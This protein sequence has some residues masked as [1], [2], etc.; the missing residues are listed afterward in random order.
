MSNEWQRRYRDLERTLEH[1][2]IA[3]RAENSS[4]S[5]LNVD[6]T[7]VEN[8]AELQ[9]IE[10]RG[11]LYIVCKADAGVERY[12]F[13][14]IKENHLVQER[15]SPVNAMEI[16]GNESRIVCRIYFEDSKST[17]PYTLEWRAEEHG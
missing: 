17:D 4:D 13:G 14:A 1:I 7:P 12:Y 9:R 15:F 5:N 6:K 16:T 11:H 10:D 8:R 3:L 2:F